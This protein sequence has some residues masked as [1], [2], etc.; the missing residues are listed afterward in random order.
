MRWPIPSSVAATV[1]FYQST[2]TNVFPEV[3]VPG[4]SS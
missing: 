4:N 1:E 3:D 2:N